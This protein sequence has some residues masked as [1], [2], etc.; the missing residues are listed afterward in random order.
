MKDIC[1][2]CGAEIESALWGGKCGCNN[3]NVVHQYK[4]NGSNKLI[5]MVIDDDYCGPEKLY[6]PDC[7]DQ[8]NYT[9]QIVWIKQG[10]KQ[11][12]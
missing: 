6:C 11:D 8:R 4:C 1:L 3:S 9:A 12:K 5:G 2:N 10:D 7:M